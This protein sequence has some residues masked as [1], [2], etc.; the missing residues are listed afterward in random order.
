MGGGFCLGIRFA[1][2]LHRVHAKTGDAGIR[3]AHCVHVKTAMVTPKSPL[4][5]AHWDIEVF[6]QH[7]KQ[8]FRVK[9]FVGTSSAN[10]VR[11]QM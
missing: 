5:M 9:S 8:P 7:L 2:S 1:D 11:I 10:A 3:L 6:F 4:Y